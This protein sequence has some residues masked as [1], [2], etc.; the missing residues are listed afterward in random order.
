MPDRLKSAVV[1]FAVLGLWGCP[2][3]RT[4]DTGDL[5]QK[6]CDPES[7]TLRDVT[8]NET[9]IAGLVNARSPDGGYAGAVPFVVDRRTGKAVVASFRWPAACPPPPTTAERGDLFVP[10]GI[11]K[12]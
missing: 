12:P 5:A 6:L 7:M 9:T 8:V 3:D 4:P 1:V 10:D 11:L 2:A